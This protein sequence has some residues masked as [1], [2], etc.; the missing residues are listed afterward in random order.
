MIL[1]FI[2]RYFNWFQTFISGLMGVVNC[3]YFCKN[4]RCSHVLVTR[5][6]AGVLM[7]N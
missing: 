4:L 6:V 5:L 3:F 2:V 7:L 1:E